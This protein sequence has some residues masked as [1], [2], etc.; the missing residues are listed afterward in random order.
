MLQVTTDLET[1]L[2]QREQLMLTLVKRRDSLV[3]Q[4]ETIIR[5][6][7]RDFDELAVPLGREIN[8]LRERLH[9]DDSEPEVKKRRNS[10]V[11]QLDGL[12]DDEQQHFL[13]LKNKRKGKR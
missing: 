6:A 11:T 12:D 8:E 10:H 7:N 5:S 13:A 4:A 9:R 2:Y 3:R 1:R